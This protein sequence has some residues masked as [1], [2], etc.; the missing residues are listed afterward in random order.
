MPQANCNKQAHRFH[1]SMKTLAILLG[2]AAILGVAYTLPAEKQDDDEGMRSLMEQL[3]RGVVVQM[4]EEE[5]QQTSAEL[6]SAMRDLLVQA[7]D[8]DEDE[9]GKLM[10]LLQEDSGEDDG[11]NL[12]A[13]LQEGDDDE[14][15][16]EVQGNE[17]D[18]GDAEM[19][20]WFSRVVGGIRR[21]GG[22]VNGICKKVQRYTRYT[23]CLPRMQA[24]IER[25]DE[26][27]D[28]LAK[29]LLRRIAN[30]QE[31]GDGDAEAQFFKSIFKKARRIWGR[32]KRFFKKIRRGVG[33]VYRGYRNIRRCI[34]RYG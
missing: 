29:D 28:E 1:P 26:G 34:K 13:L 7:Q 6:Q 4:Q 10:A 31:D 11:D 24:E 8:E 9:G 22:R 2:L 3:M 33:R 25:A 30:V 23:K 5:E 32:G 17:E 16:G 14:E 15:G 27:D 12:L 19:Q 20:G 21:F 18:E